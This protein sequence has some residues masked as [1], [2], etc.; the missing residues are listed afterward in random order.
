MMQAQ[1]RGDDDIHGDWKYSEWTTS[2]KG[3][4]DG[5]K[6]VKDEHRCTEAL[7]EED[8]PWSEDGGI[9]R[10][11]SKGSGGWPVIAKDGLREG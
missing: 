3:N 11:G 4:I 1:R 5:R 2:F 8:L 9:E 7:S 10:V 6:N